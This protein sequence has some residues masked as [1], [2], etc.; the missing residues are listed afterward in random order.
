LG[1]ASVISFSQ[2]VVIELLSR[3]PRLLRRVAFDDTS[4]FAA[5]ASGFDPHYARY[6]TVNLTE[7]KSDGACAAAWRAVRAEQLFEE[8][9]FRPNPEA[10]YE[11]P[12]WW[13]I[14]AISGVRAVVKTGE[15]PAP[16]KPVAPD[17]SAEVAVKALFDARCG[18]DCHGQDLGVLRDPK[19]SDALATGRMPKGGEPLTKAEID[20]LLGPSQA[21]APSAR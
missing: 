16:L 13:A 6:G 12:A 3:Y 19:V 1:N 17:P 2:R 11:L 10:G 4:D 18:G 7:S 5:Q 15:K 9:G 8:T 21:A 20:L 14:P